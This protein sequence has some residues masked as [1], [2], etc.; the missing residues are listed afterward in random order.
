M[1]T[2]RRHSLRRVLL[3]GRAL[4]P[5]R[6]GGACPRPGGRCGQKI[7]CLEGASGA[8]LV[9]GYTG[10]E[11]IQACRGGCPHPPAGGHK[12]RPYRVCA[13]GRCGQKVNCPAGARE[14][15][16]GRRPLHDAGN[17]GR[18]QGPPLQTGRGLC[19]GGVYPRPP[20]MRS[21]AAPVRRPPGRRPR[22]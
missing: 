18:P 3:R 13:A 10:R 8:T 9:G 6:R 1:R 21:R 15:A 11:K 22:P 5:R 16:L 14:A 12:G 7:N 19:R 4:Q 20:P 2:R 17:G